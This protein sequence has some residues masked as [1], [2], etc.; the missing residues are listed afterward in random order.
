MIWGDK[1]RYELT[2]VND[3]PSE[4]KGRV[5]VTDIVSGRVIYEGTFSVPA[6][7]RCVISELSMPAGQGLCLIEYQIGEQTFQN[8]YLYGEPPFPLNDYRKWIKDLA[9]SL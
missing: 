8:H 1:G 2:A 6:N 7:S 3:T 9:P 5:K 4:G